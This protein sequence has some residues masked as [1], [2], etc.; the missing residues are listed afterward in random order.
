M[1][2]FHIARQIGSEKSGKKKAILIALSLMLLLGVCAF[3]LP[4][5]VKSA[6]IANQIEGLE[7]DLV[8][9]EEM[10]KKHK[11][12]ELCLPDSFENTFHQIKASFPYVDNLLTLRNLFLAQASLSNVEVEQCFFSPPVSLGIEVPNKEGISVLGRSD[13]DFRGKTAYKNL[14]ILTGMLEATELLYSINNIDIS[15]TSTEDTRVSY[16]L[17]LKAVYRTKPGHFE[18]IEEKEKDH[19]EDLHPR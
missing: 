19:S 6:Q 11:T 4:A 18:E 15:F 2:S 8:D 12:L 17:G 14:L 13:I 5:F 10:S 1:K 3:P 7:K 16:R 9:L